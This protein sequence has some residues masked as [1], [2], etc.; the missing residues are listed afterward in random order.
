MST[1]KPLTR[2]SIDSARAARPGF[3]HADG[4]RCGRRLQPPAACRMSGR[5]SATC[6]TRSSRMAR[7]WQ[8]GWSRARSSCY[9]LSWA[10]WSAEM[11]DVM[12]TIYQELAELERKNELAALCT[13]VRSQGSTPRQ[14]TSKMLVYPDGTF[15]GTVG[16]GEMENR[17]I[18]E[19]TA[20]HAG[21]QAAPGG[22]Q[23][24][25]PRPGRPRRVRRSG[26]D[27]CGADTTQTYPGG[28]RRRACWQS[29]RASGPLAGISGGGQR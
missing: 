11:A 17:V 23:Y 16:G 18:A 2:R 13:V 5:C 15:I 14:A 27:L 6:L 19:A 8:K 24:E 29:S 1:R 10:C 22:I 4:H 3:C 20:G 9:R 7:A 26:G 28:D 25:R 12:K 21:W